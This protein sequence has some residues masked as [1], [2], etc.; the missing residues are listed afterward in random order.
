[1]SVVSVKAIALCVL[2]IRLLSRENQSKNHDCVFTEIWSN[3]L[4]LF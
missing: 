2:E 1:M 3:E 4:S